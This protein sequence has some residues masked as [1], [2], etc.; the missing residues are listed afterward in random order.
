MGC[1]CMLAALNESTHT[2]PTPIRD[3]P[4][5]LP[6]PEIVLYLNV[7]INIITRL[8]MA[9]SIPPHHHIYTTTTHTHILCT[10]KYPGI[11]PC[12]LAKRILMMSYLLSQE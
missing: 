6:K 8:G 5:E 1:L 7:V 12:G 2:T 3:V 10:N 11:F 9:T 4:R